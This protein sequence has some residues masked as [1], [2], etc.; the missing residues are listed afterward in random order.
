MA[1]N[2]TS[3]R[4]SADERGEVTL[5]NGDGHEVTLSDPASIMS[6]VYGLGYR[7]KDDT[8]V[9]EAVIAATPD[10]AVSTPSE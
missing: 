1:Q 5:V 9:Q 7:V 6:H 2:R 4:G 10:E 8:P 3:R